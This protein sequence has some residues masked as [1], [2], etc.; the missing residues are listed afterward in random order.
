MQSWA[1]YLDRLKNGAA[2]ILLTNRLGFL[3]GV[4]SLDFIS[5]AILIDEIG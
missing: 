5:I 1:D 4:S 3:F 2:F